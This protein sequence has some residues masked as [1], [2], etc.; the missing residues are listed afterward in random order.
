M[1]I[2]WEEEELKTIQRLE[3]FIVNSTDRL[4]VKR[5]ITDMN[6]ATERY[7]KKT[8]LISAPAPVDF[9]G[10]CD[11]T[12]KGELIGFYLEPIT[13]YQRQLNEKPFSKLI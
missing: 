5:A 12:F 10:R 4:A 9:M 7:I 8:K 6:L 13:K 3:N 2:I 1:N 11:Y